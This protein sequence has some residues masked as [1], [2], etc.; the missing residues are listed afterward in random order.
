MREV[1]ALS[2]GDLQRSRVV[3]RTELVDELLPVG[4]DRVQLQQVVINLLRNAA[5]AMSGVDDRP[6]QLVIRTEPDEEAGVRLSVKDAGIGF[7]PEG[8]ERL[9]EAFYTTKSDGMGIGLSVS[10]SIIERITGACGRHPMMVRGSRSASP[11][12]NT[13]EETVVYTR[14]APCRRLPRSYQNAAEIS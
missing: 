2:S 9:F 12:R 4:G 13:G 11:S 5:D 7:G 6:R 10:R 14:P 1:I 3:L 8:A